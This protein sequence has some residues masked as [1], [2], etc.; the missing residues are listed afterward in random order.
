M[1]FVA[2]IA[3]FFLLPGVL[4]ALSHQLKNWRTITATEQTL[5]VLTLIGLITAVMAFVGLAAFG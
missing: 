5:G 3:V 2:V 4:Y 1:A